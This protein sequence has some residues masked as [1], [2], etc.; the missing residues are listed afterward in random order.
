MEEQVILI[1]GATDGI[2]S[3]TAEKLAQKGASVLV[4]GRIPEKCESTLR[5]IREN[6][7]NE[8]LKTYVADLASLSAVR[9]LAEE[10]ASNHSELHV[11]INNAGVGPPKPAGENPLSKDG[12]E[13][14]FAVNY[15]APFL[16]THLLTPLLR[17]GAPS[18][19]VNVSSAAQE[20]IDFDMMLEMNYNPWSAYAQ[21]KLA[22]TMFTFDIAQQLKNYAI[23]ANC[24]H[25]GSLLD[26]KMVRESFGTPLGSAE[27]GAEA[28]VYVA[29]D[30]VLQGKTGKYFDQKREARAHEQAYDTEV[31]KTLRQISEELTGIKLRQIA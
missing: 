15:L 26:T 4:H 9:E 19:I 31:R 25:P 30:P 22:L 1:T 12:Y 11:L 10:V 21:S 5:G 23:T 8:K 24:L 20:P 16:L 18:R 3:I 13:I 17:R 28:E 2:G 7:G 27:S 29:M 14:C 6:S